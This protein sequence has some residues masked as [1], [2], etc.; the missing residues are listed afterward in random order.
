VEPHNRIVCAR[1]LRYHN[2]IGFPWRE[3]GE[4]YGDQLLFVGLPDEHAAFEKLLGRSIEHANTP[5]FLE[6]AKIMAG[7]PQIVANQSAP[8]WVAM[9]LGRKVICEVCPAVPNSVIPRPGSYFAMTA[10]HMAVLR[11]AFANARSK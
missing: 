4:T 9:G 3:L 2:P 1:S 6:I 11:R 7:A 10:A 8:L 5:D